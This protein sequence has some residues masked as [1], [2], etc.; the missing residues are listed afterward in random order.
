MIDDTVARCAGCGSRYTTRAW[1]WL[2]SLGGDGERRVCPVVGCGAVVGRMPRSANAGGAAT[3]RANAVPVDVVFV[4][5][6]L[7]SVPEVRFASAFVESADPHDCGPLTIMLQGQ[8]LQM[9]GP[10]FD[11]DGDLASFCGAMRARLTMA[12][13]DREIRSAETERSAAREWM[14]EAAQRLEF[15]HRHFGDGKA[16]VLRLVPPEGER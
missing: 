8:R 4:D 3:A 5:V 16:K 6:P 1:P 9:I 14:A 15:A 11:F 10:G 7:P 2:E 12:E 13:A